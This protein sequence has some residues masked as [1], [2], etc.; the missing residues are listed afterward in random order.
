METRTIVNAITKILSASEDERSKKI[1][2]D[3]IDELHGSESGG[4]WR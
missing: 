2:Q 1:L 3:L 4:G